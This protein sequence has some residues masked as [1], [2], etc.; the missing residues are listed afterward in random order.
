MM[1]SSKMMT[2]TARKPRGTKVLVSASS[3]IFKLGAVYFDCP[4]Y[5]F[6]FL[7]VELTFI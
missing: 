5:Y 3:K 1:K 4:F 7:F 6:I 2:L